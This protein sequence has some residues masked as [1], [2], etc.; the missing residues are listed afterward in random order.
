MPTNEE[1]IVYGLL[2]TVELSCNDKK[3]QAKHLIIPNLSFVT[4]LL[5]FPSS[6][7][8]IRPACKMKGRKNSP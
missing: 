8:S 2:Y 1:R 4:N 6:H 3:K 5:I 7:C